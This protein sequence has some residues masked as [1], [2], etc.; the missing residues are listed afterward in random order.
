MLDVATALSAGAR[1]GISSAV[2]V[3]WLGEVA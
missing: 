3:P 1:G 2:I